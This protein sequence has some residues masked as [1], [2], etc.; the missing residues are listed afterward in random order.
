MFIRY[1][2]NGRHRYV[3]QG[4]P[5]VARE[6]E[7]ADCGRGSATAVKQLRTKFYGLGDGKNEFK[8][9]ENCIMNGCSAEEALTLRPPGH[10]SVNNE[11]K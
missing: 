10:K 2:H 7:K 6:L 9:Y 3:D 11:A 8:L 5:G 1:G 4:E